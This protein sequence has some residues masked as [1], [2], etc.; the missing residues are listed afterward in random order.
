LE[1]L[2]ELLTLLYID[3]DLGILNDDKSELELVNF[4]FLVSF[5]FESLE[6]LLLLFD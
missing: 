1:L 2:K 4:N 3:L 5:E 6:L